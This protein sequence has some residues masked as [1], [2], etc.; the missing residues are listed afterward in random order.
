[1]HSLAKKTLTKIHQDFWICT[2]LTVTFIL[3]EITQAVF[4]DT[5]TSNH[6]VNVNAEV[7]FSVISLIISVLDQSL[8]TTFSNSITTYS[9]R[10]ISDHYTEVTSHYSDLWADKRQM[11]KISETD[12]II[13][14]LIND[15]DLTKMTVKV[16]SITEK[17]YDEINKAFNKLHS[18]E[19]MKYLNEL[20]SFTYSVFVVWWIITKKNDT[21]IK[22]TKVV[23]NIR[24]LNKI[25]MSDSYSLSQ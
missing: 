11:T 1:M 19:R 24:D 6:S 13:I 21:I 5:T 16:Y 15:W 4:S 20:I 7:M 23:I 14:S 2:A 17:D 22:K 18:Q 12:W 10:K 8:E 25:I 9:E 3:A